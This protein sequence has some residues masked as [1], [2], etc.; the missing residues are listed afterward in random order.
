MKLKEGFLLHQVG[1]EYMAVASGEAGK[2]FHGLV[3]NNAT[4]AFIFEQLMM[5][6]DQQQIVAAMAEKYD[7]PIEQIT[8]DVDR[9]LGLIQEAGFLEE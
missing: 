6:T 7:A 9:I 1:E 4:A 5:E 2:A 8:K 3:R